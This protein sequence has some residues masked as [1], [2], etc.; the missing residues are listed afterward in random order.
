MTDYWDSIRDRLH[1][2]SGL[3]HG[4]NQMAGILKCYID[5]ILNNFSDDN[6]LL[7]D[8]GFLL[9]SEGLYLDLRG[10]ELGLPRKD[11]QWATGT[12]VFFLLKKLS[13]PPSDETNTSG[14][15][16]NDDGGLTFDFTPTAMQSMLDKLNEDYEEG[17]PYYTYRECTN[18]FTI[19]T[20]TIVCSDAGFEYKLTEDL[21]FPK[22]EIAVSGTIIAT[23][24]GSRFNTTEVDEVCIVQTSGINKDLACTNLTEITGG[25]DGEDDNEYRR[26]LLNSINTNISVNY[27]KRQ[28]IIIYTKKELDDAVRLKMTSLNPYLNNKYCAIPPNDDVTFFMNHELIANKNVIVYIKGWDK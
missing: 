5:G 23:Q 8:Q 7:V 17:K 3:H 11:G 24:S 14:G 9:T 16:E 4:N 6:R 26:R 2:E 19:P 25:Y 28:S 27:L 18:D 20:G 1:E 10:D 15:V 22:G 12:I 13:E 21:V